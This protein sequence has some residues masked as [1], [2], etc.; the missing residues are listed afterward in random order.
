MGDKR[1]D[2]PSFFF[3]I[4]VG[5]LIIFLV[6]LSYAYGES[7]INQ[8]KD[9]ICGFILGFVLMFAIHKIDWSVGF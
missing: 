9:L 7:F 8:Y 4:W 3:G 1:F 5:V 6:V 2:F